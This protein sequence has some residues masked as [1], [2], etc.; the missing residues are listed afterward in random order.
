M[1]ADANKV[2]ET[3]T[4][5]TPG[6]I[7]YEIRDRKKKDEVKEEKL[8]TAKVRARVGYYAMITC[9]D[10]PE[11]ELNLVNVDTY[12]DLEL[13][14]NVIGWLDDVV[15]SR[16]AYTD[17]QAPYEMIEYP[18]GS[19]KYRALSRFELN[20]G[21][22]YSYEQLLEIYDGK[23]GWSNTIPQGNN[24]NGTIPAVPGNPVMPGFPASVPNLAFA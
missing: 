23:T 2:V 17:A 10:P 24:Y 11:D 16:P 1:V 3:W 22:E 20:I 15:V 18:E 12:G 19:K 6:M 4:T 8:I 9:E 7:Y 21:R 13:N 14:N 5:S